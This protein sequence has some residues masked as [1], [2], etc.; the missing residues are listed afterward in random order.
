LIAA[1][2]RGALAGAGLDVFETEPGI[3]ARLLARANVVVTAHMGSAVHE[4][5]AAMAGIVVDNIAAI[6]A[7]RPAPNCCNPEVYVRSRPTT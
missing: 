2:G 7:G 3:D 6:V 1:L 5:R 4:L